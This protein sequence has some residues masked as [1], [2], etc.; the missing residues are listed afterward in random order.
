MRHVFLVHSHV[1][2][3]VARGVAEFEDLEP[4]RVLRLAARTFGPRLPESGVAASSRVAV[5]DPV[6]L[7]R[8]LNVPE[9]RSRLRL[10]DRRVEA[11]VGGGRYHAY[12]PQTRLRWIQALLSHPRCAGFSLIEEGLASY[13]TRDELAAMYP[14]EVLGLLGRLCYGRRVGRGEFFAPG[15]AKA[16]G[17][18]ERSFPD[19]PRRVVLPRPPWH[20]GSGVL[21][22]TV[23]TVL[24]FDGLSRFGTLRLES[25]LH[26]VERTLDTLA[27]RGVDRLHY[28]LHPAQLG[29]DEVGRIEALFARR[30]T[31][32]AERLPDG[33]ALE[34]LAARKPDVCFLVNVSSV[35]LYAALLGCPVESYAPFVVEAEPEFAEHV[36]R[37]PRVYRDRVRFLAD[38]T[39]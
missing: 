20:P 18:T 6:R 7:G 5:L 28:K 32:A 21:D 4:E 26:A 34:E 12:V 38:A 1:T 14:P 22:A 39:R 37:L 27:A 19:L 8:G 10:L 24:V 29:S 17:L 11:V 31:P 33:L 15:H 2:D 25:V 36:E 16:Y 30:R 13:R 9:R 35:G 3:F 23:E